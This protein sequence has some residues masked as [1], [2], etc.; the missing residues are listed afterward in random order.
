MLR[1]L[2]TASLLLALS[3]PALAGVTPIQAIRDFIAQ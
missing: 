1:T 3:L 2:L